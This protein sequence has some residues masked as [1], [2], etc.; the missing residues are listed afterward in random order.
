MKSWCLGPNGIGFKMCSGVVWIL[1]LELDVQAG[2]RCPVCCTAGHM[3][4]A[5]QAVRYCIPPL[6][7]GD[8]SSIL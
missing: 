5:C 7:E 2:G 1:G 3:W 4:A 8:G 6:P